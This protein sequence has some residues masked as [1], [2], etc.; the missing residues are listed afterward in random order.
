MD[1]DRDHA[2]SSPLRY[3]LKM[4][5]R[6]L[7]EARVQRAL[8]L[9][10]AGVRRLYPTRRVQSLYLDTPS[11]RALEDNIAGISER[12]KV[13]F[14][15]Y[16]PQARAVSG[17]LERKQRRNTLGWKDLCEFDQPLDVEGVPRER[18]VQN[19][20]ERVPDEWLSPLNG[21]EPVQWIAYEREYLVSADGLLRI[22]L[23]TKLRSWEQRLRRVLAPTRP[24][25]LPRVLIVEL[26]CAPE[27][28]ELA[29]TLVQGLPLQVD[30]CSKFVM[31]SRREH[32]PHPSVLSD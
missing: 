14:R 32:A 4:V 12:T 3:E 25:P 15:W 29:R 18:F 27:H 16:G 17:R 21:L 7:D 19:L 9:H 26:K 6:E 28:H 22:T 11:N 8:K 31:A 5:C 23:D 13:R 30:K 10:P 2:R 24:S 20:R 1:A